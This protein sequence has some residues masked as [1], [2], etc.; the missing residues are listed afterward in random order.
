[1]LIITLGALLQFCHS[2]PPALETEID[3]ASYMDLDKDLKFASYD[4]MEENRDIHWDWV[5]KTGFP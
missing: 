5:G 3:Q 1:M 2:G 4:T